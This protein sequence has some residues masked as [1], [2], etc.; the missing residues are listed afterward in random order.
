MYF[1]DFASFARRNLP[2]GWNDDIGGTFQ[3]L[4]GRWYNSSR[5]YWRGNFTYESPFILLKPL[6]R[7]LGLVQQ[8]R[9]VWWYPVHATFLIHILSWVMASAHIYLMWGFL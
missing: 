9:F 1:V 8:E 2:E 7:W 4:D 6:N 5:Q 3:L